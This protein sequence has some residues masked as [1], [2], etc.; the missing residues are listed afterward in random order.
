MGVTP[1]PPPQRHCICHCFNLFLQDHVGLIRCRYLIFSTPTQTSTLKEI[2]W[3]LSHDRHERWQKNTTP[4][5]DQLDLVKLTRVTLYWTYK[6]FNIWHFD[7]RNGFFFQVG[8]MRCL[9]E[10]LRALL[11]SP[12][13]LPDPAHYWSCLSPT[14][15]FDRTPDRQPGT[16]YFEN[17]DN[18]NWLGKR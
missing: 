7:T 9:K 17:L 12:F 14:R 16:G 10:C 3:R 11:P 18:T 4:C 1:R 15:F 5:E 2:L 8:R 6:D 13:S